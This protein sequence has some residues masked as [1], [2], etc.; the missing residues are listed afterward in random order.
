MANNPLYDNSLRHWLDFTTP[1]YGRVEI[2]E[3]LNF[4]SF[5]FKIK[6]RN[7]GFGRDKEIG[8]EEI[9]LEFGNVY[10]EKAEFP[11]TLIN[12][13]I[14]Y[15]LSHRLDLLFEAKKEGGSECDIKYI[16]SQNDVD[17][18]MG[19]LDI[20]ESTDDCYSYLKCSV[21][22][23]T[24]KALIERKKD[25]KA[26]V[27][28]TV[29]TFGNPQI[30]LEKTK[31]LLKSKPIIQSSK[32]GDKSVNNIQQIGT[33]LN[34]Q[35]SIPVSNKLLKSDIQDSYA[36]F[37]VV[38]QGLDVTFEENNK[39]RY[40]NSFLT[41]KEALSGIK[42]K[43]NK[44]S[45]SGTTN[46]GTYTLNITRAIFDDDGNWVANVGD[47][48]QP[49]IEENFVSIT[50]QDYEID[51]PDMNQGETLNVSM[52]CFFATSG[53]V[54]FDMNFTSF[55]IESMEI[56]LTS[57]A[58]NSV[59]DGV[60]Y[61]DFLEHGIKSI[62][63]LEFVANDMETGEFKDQFVFNGN[64]I[65]QKINTPL[66]FVFKDEMNDLKE[67]NSDYQIYNDKVGVFQYPDFYRFQ[68]MGAFLQIPDLKFE[69]KFNDRFK[70]IS[71]NYSYKT[72]EQDRNEQNT[73]DAFHTEAQFLFPNTKVDE[74]LPI[75]I[76]HIR[77]PFTIETAR[78][79]AISSTTALTTDDKIFIIDCVQLPEGSTGTITRQLQM[80][81]REPFGLNIRS[82]GFKWSLLGFENADLVTITFGENQGDYYV[83]QYTDDILELTTVGLTLPE[84]SGLS[85]ITFKYPLS[86]VSWVNRTD[87]GFELIENIENANEVSNLKY[88]IK[89]NLTRN[90]WSS[91]LATICK[92]NLDGV[93]RNT[94][95]KVNGL[96]TTQF[97][98]GEILEEKADIIVSTLSEKIL[99]KYEYKTQVAIGFEEA[100]QLIE[101]V[102]NLRGFIRIYDTQNRVIKIHPKLLDMSWADG[103]MEIVGESRNE[104]DFIVITSNTEGINIF[105]VGY[106]TIINRE[107]D[108]FKIINDYVQIFDNDQ[109]PLINATNFRKISVNGILFTDVDLFYQT[110]DNL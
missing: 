21:V 48:I 59:I 78:R 56:T 58:I 41:A 45:V 16:V 90:A 79:E 27:F 34:C 100:K 14:V 109:K 51:I 15:E 30:P 101:D 23:N 39:Y 82:N 47:A 81:V 20:P 88:T 54:S 25:I 67:T 35:I 94:D 55:S 72:Y 33:A 31:V 44:L 69:R 26:N 86:G 70:K 22:Q 105:N 95:F 107:L 64:L 49:I 97:Y 29:D 1:N 108:W 57:T 102:I 46:L 12:G 17:F 87:E 66:N 5:S 7:D 32:W 18:V 98:G 77:D 43:I 24:N 62:S 4:D 37:D 63:G 61:F 75:A 60:P 19:L 96:L 93:I 50:D 84:F 74:D 104:S 91:Y 73:V 42:L 68:D 40:A 71:L 8:A 89:R 53:L 76:N 38:F 6:Q 52:T 80:Q 92:D 9:D 110:L 3:P 99:D 83:L 28:S 2:T 36:P 85:L 103:V 11:Q 13:T 10:G 106:D 65:R